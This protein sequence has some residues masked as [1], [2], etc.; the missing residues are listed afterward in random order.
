MVKKDSKSISIKP[1]LAVMYENAHRKILKASV[2]VP[3]K[4]FGDFLV[5]SDDLREFGISERDYSYGVVTLLKSWLKGKSYLHRIP[6]NVF[7][8]TWAL[9]R[10]LKVHNSEYVKVEQEDK[11][12]EILLH[13]ELI[14]A[15]YYISKNIHGVVRRSAVIK[16]LGGM[17][18]NL[19]KNTPEDDRP[20]MKVLDILYEEFVLKKQPL[21]YDD[22]TKELR[23]R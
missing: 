10:F 21:S 12:A 17:L 4:D 16:D 5:M 7:C 23:C 11:T 13:D 18:S 8:G 3:E 20:V 2:W 15:R 9:E 1:N 14:F 6:T 19:W 22:I